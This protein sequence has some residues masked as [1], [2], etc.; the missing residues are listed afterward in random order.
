MSSNSYMHNPLIHRD[1]RLGRSDSQ[2][3]RS[4]DCEDMSVLIVCRGPIRR[5]ALDI[6][7]EMGM[8][9]V[10]ILLSEKDSIVYPRALAPELRRLDPSRVHS[11][12][13]YTGAS[14]EER[15]E[16][17]Q[18]II[19]IAK[20][21]GYGYIFAGYG[22]M[23]E[24]EE[25]V[26]SI[27]EAGLRF[28]GPCSYTVQA[29][30]FKDEAKRTA[31]RVD[32]SVTPG[33][34]NATA[35][36][37]LKNHPDRQ[38]LAKLAK[39]HGLDVPELSNDAVDL[40]ALADALLGAAYDAHIDLYTVDELA[41]QMKIEVASIL[42]QNPGSRVRLKAIGGGGGKGQRIV[43]RAEQAPAMVREILSEV[44]ALGVGDNKNILVELNIETTRHNEIQLLGNGEWTISLGGRDC[45]LQMH[46]QKLL[47]VSITQET[48]AAAVERE[49]AAGNE[50]K[51]SAIEQDL[52]ILRRME[53]QAERFGEAVK[54]DSASTFECIVDGPRHYFMEV[55][56][57]IQV[58]HRVSELCYALRFTNPEDPDDFFDVHS[59]VEA[60][61][62]LAKHKAR[63]PRP[64]RIQRD[65]AAVE[66]R[67]N[68]TDQSLSPH[69]G[70]EI[71]SWS[72]PI[73]GEVRDDQGI[74]FK[75]PDTNL[76]M[77]Y[78]LAGAY[79]SNIALLVTTGDDRRDSY[80][81]LR[82][83][84][85]RTVLRG[86]DLQTNLQFH[87]G[88]VH[89][90]LA[91][92]V[93]AKPTTRFV[94]PYL[95]LV[96]EL[97]NEANEIDP[98]YAYDRLAGQYL[99]AASADPAAAKATNDLC[100]LKKTLLGRP[101]G[102]ILRQPHLFS[103]WLSANKSSFEVES[104]RVTWLKNPVQV[105]ADT[106]YL[107]YM[108]AGVDLPAAHRIWEQD[109]AVLRDG[110]AFYATA[111]ERLGIEGWPE[112]DVAL[113]AKKAPKGFDAKQWQHVREA[114]LG[115]QL[116]MELYSLLPLIGHKVGFFD[117]HVKD[118]L[119]ID[120]P[121]RLF[122]REH[123]A[124]MKKVLVPPPVNKADEIVA[125]SGGMYYAQ[126]AP[127]MP[128]FVEE[129]QHFEIG[130]PLYIVEVMKMFN[131]VYAPFAGTVDKILVDTNGTIVSKGQPL[132]KVTPD[133][134]F[135]EQDPALVRARVES[136]TEK[137]L[138]VVA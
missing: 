60:M 19:E 81:R 92:G 102:R 136:N 65:A 29:A 97:L 110:A 50:M 53:E 33:T 37:V 74:S 82:E 113:K 124:K 11:V 36:L 86:P 76:F 23:A 54:L 131:K 98:D 68:A 99:D 137:Y 61:A 39:K 111:Q 118:D 59:I 6:F 49:R 129:G 26:R 130:D 57:R 87:Y 15:A 73:E 55:N 40:E 77:R 117:L 12:S 21:N 20:V 109:E 126:E 32:V 122:D 9:R 56:T 101:M 64:T 123:Q 127:G 120:I 79:D 66:A 31:E 10:G 106:Y 52:E 38:A 42:Q 75:N 43:D 30:G 44:K 51:A 67:L 1:R 91:N 22:F 25:F 14:K 128:H 112:L 133:E 63:L 78:R 100:I 103:A 16:R 2:W 70:G 88:L 93:D 83:V 17:I 94:V 89:W 96:G 18:Q 107:L 134:K 45:S 48:L 72:D 135:V 8:T 114:H 95:T 105:L 90:F 71:M 46:E 62:L 121:E 104:G 84:L 80:E 119:T 4:F 28:A 27:E 85:R 115:F 116:G 138:S 5:E 108:D 13:D 24:D 47:E 69:A 132:F 125:V 7:E 3:V 58:E 35:R 41:E 34:N